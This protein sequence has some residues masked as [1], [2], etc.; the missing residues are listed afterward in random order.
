M[1]DWIH[2]FLPA[3]GFDST[4]L[5]LHE[6]GAN[7]NDLVPIGRSVAR[8]SGLLSPRL[9]VPDDVAAQ[10]GELAEFVRESAARYGFDAGKVY[11]LGY[12]HGADLGAALML[13]DPA[14]LAGGIWLRPRLTVK[15]ERLPDLQGAPVL[16]LAG[17]QD[18]KARPEDTEL[19]AR[20]L[21]SAGAAGEV[22]WMNEGHELGPEDFQAAAKWMRER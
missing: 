6:A 4:V 2:R 3:N 7:E 9:R 19:L 14:V 8:G 11:G 17:Q 16:I 18:G 20:T 15:A 12:S 1:T 22:H 21:T 5:L 13:L 10:A